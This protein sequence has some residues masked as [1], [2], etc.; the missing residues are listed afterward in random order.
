M[1]FL[2]ESYEFETHRHCLMAS[3]ISLDCR[4]VGINPGFFSRFENRLQ[5][6]GA[7]TGMRTNAMII[8][9][10]HLSK[11]PIAPKSLWILDRAAPAGIFF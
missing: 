9:N 3:M 2:R 5:V 6:V 11:P 8:V 7:V 4:A 1:P 10:C